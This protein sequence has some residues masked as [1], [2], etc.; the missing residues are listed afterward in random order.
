MSWTIEKG[1]VVT[2]HEEG[3]KIQPGEIGLL[4]VAVT[5]AE[6]LLQQLVPV[7]LQPDLFLAAVVCVGWN[8]FPFKGGLSGTIFGLVAD[9]LLGVYLGL[10]GLSKTLLGFSASYLGR[11]LASESRLMRFALLVLVAFVDKMILAGMLLLLGASQPHPFWIYTGSE[12][13]A[14]GLFG[15]L[16][17][18]FYDRL[19]LPPKNFRRLTS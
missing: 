19:K 18:R 12:A 11:W 8:S 17:F 4:L 5:V 10:N 7:G 14:T 3:F 2:K 15:E 1:I 16:L 13:L 9:T 6:V